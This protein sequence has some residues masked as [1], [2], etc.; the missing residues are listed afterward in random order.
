MTNVNLIIYGL[1]LLLPT[2]ILFLLGLYVGQKIPDEIELGKI[3]IEKV[4]ETAPYNPQAQQIYR[5][6][7]L[8]LDILQWGTLAVGI[9]LIISGL[10]GKNHYI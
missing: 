6:T 4:N 1:F 3:I 7:I 10:S 8:A 2:V 9:I 5:N